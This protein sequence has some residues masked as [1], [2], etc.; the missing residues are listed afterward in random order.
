MSAAPFSTYFPGQEAE[1]ASYSEHKN[2]VV[3]SGNIYVRASTFDGIS[4]EG[5]GGA[6]FS[7][8]RIAIVLSKFVNCHSDVQGGAIA[9]YAV[10]NSPDRAFYCT[11]CVAIGCN[12]NDASNTNPD[13][14]KGEFFYS[15]VYDSTT[16]N[17]AS[18][19]S[20]TKCAE[21]VSDSCQRPLFFIE[22]KVTA[23]TINVSDCKNGWCSC[24]EVR[25]ATLEDCKYMLISNCESKQV[26]IE[27]NQASGTF[28]Y[29]TI[30]KCGTTMVDTPFRYFTLTS[31]QILFDYISVYDCTSRQNDIFHSINGGQLS[32]NNVYL[33]PGF[34]TSNITVQN[35]LES[36]TE[37]L[38]EFFDESER[39]NVLI[40]ETSSSTTT[41][42]E[43]PSTST[44]SSE[45]PSTS[46]TSSSE[47]KEQSQPQPQPED[48]TPKPTEET[49]KPTEVT[50]SGGGG[51]SSKDG[52]IL[53]MAKKNFIIMIVCVV[54][55]VLI[56][57]VVIVVLIIRKGKDVDS[58][59]SDSDFNEADIAAIS[60]PETNF[61]TETVVDDNNMFTTNQNME[62]D[63]FKAD[64]NKVDSESDT[65]LNTDDL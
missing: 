6:I 51:D 17:H 7:A 5:S 26:I 34:E 31:S 42:S 15:H 64:F 13:H 38:T 22:G 47:E 10:D 16:T 18:E 12:T 36:Q 58:D 25:T 49:P 30:T 40:A 56:I 28:S 4:D 19:L 61:P 1:P 57:I 35:T 53:G 55:V 24:M 63:P 41:S 43:S 62:D 3:G 48:P 46:T 27:F 39:E 54:V 29:V 23:K 2:F 65:D 8:T 33:Q 21:E 45:S 20:V 32:L 37:F 52:Q 14:Q 11:Q 9:V 59:K 60:S 50:K 44:S